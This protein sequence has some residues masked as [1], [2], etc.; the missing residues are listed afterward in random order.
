MRA[1]IVGFALVLLGGTASPLKAAELDDL[2]SRV[3]ELETRVDDLEAFK[4]IFHEWKRHNDT[5]NLQLKLETDRFMKRLTDQA[6]KEMEQGKIG[7]GAPF[8]TDGPLP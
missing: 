5:R 2:K 8:Y 1:L 4:N 6:K 3:D 7:R